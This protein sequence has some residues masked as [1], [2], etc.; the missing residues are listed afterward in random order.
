MLPFHEIYF[1]A[2]LRGKGLLL[3]QKSCGSR[4]VSAE[5]G[6]AAARKANVSLRE[7]A[8]DA[9]ADFLAAVAVAGVGK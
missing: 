3:R 8:K 2:N 6:A 7:S 5:S 4:G 1:A 9:A